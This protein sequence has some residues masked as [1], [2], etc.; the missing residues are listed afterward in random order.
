[1]KKMKLIALAAMMVLS[2]AFTG[3]NNSV[4]TEPANETQKQNEMAFV[5]QLPEATKARVAYYEQSD[6]TSYKVQLLKS[7][8]V[9]KTETGNPGDKIR[10]T[11]AEEGSYSIQ[12]TA[13]KDTTVIAEG[14]SPV[15]IS[16]AD[17]DVKVNVKLIPNAKEVGIDVEI[18]WGSGAET[19]VLSANFVKVEGSTVAGGTKFAY[20]GNLYNDDYLKGVFRKGRTV[21][22]DSFYMCDHEVTQ[23]EYVSIM[24]TNPSGFNNNAAG[25]EVQENL[26]VESVSWYNAI[27][28]CNKRSIAEKLTPCY[29]IS[30]STN[31]AD[32]GEVPASSDSTWDAVNCNFKTSGYRLPTEVEWEYAA[33]GGKN[34]VTADDP[35]DFAG[36]NDISELGEYAWYTSNSGSKTHEVRKKLSN[37]LGLYDMS[38]NVWE[39]CWDWYDN[40]NTP[41]IISST[42]ATGVTSGSS[43]VVRGGSW[44]VVAEY[45][46]VADRCYDHPDDRFDR[47]G[48]RVVRSAQ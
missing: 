29:S 25:G 38:G 32:W 13:Y 30:G 42:P 16:L 33:L 17:G 34:G 26:P 48:F 22:I 10:L 6:A 46:S 36:T 4:G 8:T 20:S 43:R 11:V 27:V 44:N 3:C 47:L 28:Y 2:S 31:P 35:T 5:I 23:A 39:W 15:S 21:T 45:C 40:E 41:S 9:L 37:A 7:G 18:E 1:M 19:P 14:L 12:V 24:G